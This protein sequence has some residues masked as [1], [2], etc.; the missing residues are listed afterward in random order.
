MP[1]LPDSLADRQYY[2]PTDRGFEKEIRKRLEE[3]KK[4]KNSQRPPN[5]QT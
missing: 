2:N 5:A 4:R 1:C 3:W